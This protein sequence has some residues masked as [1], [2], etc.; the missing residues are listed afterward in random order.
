MMALVLVELFFL[1][2]AA[3]CYPRLTLG[4]HRWKGP[5]I[6]VLEKLNKAFTQSFE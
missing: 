1:L 6:A 5:E 2:C 4:K 3:D